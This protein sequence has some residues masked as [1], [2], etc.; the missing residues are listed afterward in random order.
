MEVRKKREK[1]KHRGLFE[2]PPG[3]GVWWV[4]YYENGKQR[5]EKVGSKS[6]A[7]DLYRSR[8]DAIREGRKLPQLRSTRFISLAELIDDALEYVKGH[9]DLRNYESKAVIVKKALG[10]RPAAEILP[11][12]IERFLNGHC[13]TNGTYNRYRA[14]ISL[15]YRQGLRNRKVTSNPARDTIS[16]K[17]SSGRYRFLDREEYNLLLDAIRKL[18][19]EHVGEFIFSVHTGMRLSEQYTMT[20]SQVDL[21]RKE[22]HLSKTKNGHERDV[23][24]NADALAVLKSLKRGKAKEAVFPR[25]GAT[26]DT[27]SWF[28]PSMAEAGIEGYVWHCNRHTFC[29]WLAMAGATIKEI[30]EAAG[31]RSIT[32]SARYS[33]LSP[34]HKAS[35]VDR[36]AGQA[37]T[38]P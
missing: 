37:P 20:W 18:F 14:F 34:K 29:S 13:K 36:I 23:H 9:K 27:R 2:R 10:A 19:P 22:I 21:D 28:R 30:Q 11:L 25:E 32:M 38:Q 35:V 6:A 33:H 12:D 31:H 15:C 8:K 3:S 16:K 7:I 5:R 17:E 26:F 1:V 24:L 4:N